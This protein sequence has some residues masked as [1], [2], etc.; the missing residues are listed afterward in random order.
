[1]RVTRHFAALRGAFLLALLA[2]PPPLGWAADP[3]SVLLTR[4][5]ATNDAPLYLSGLSSGTFV[6]LDGR[7]T[8]PIDQVNDDYCDCLDGSDEPGTAAC[9]GAFNVGFWCPSVGF[10][11]QRVPSTRVADG[12]CDCCDGSDELM[13]HHVHCDNTCAEQAAKVAQEELLRRERIE[14]A[15]SIRS[16]AIAKGREAK[17][18]RRA[19]AAELPERVEAAT[20]LVEHWET[21]LQQAEAL[22]REEKEALETVAVSTFQKAL[23]LLSMPHAALADVLLDI[24]L[25]KQEE[26]GEALADTVKGVL[27]A[28]H[29]FEDTAVLSAALPVTQDDTPARKILRE[30]EERLAEAEKAAEAA[31][32]DSSSAGLAAQNVAL[33]KEEVEAAKGPLEAERVQLERER[34]V[35]LAQAIRL[36]A[37]STEQIAEVLFIVAKTT[38]QFKE[39]TDFVKIRGGAD[40]SSVVPGDS[41][42]HRRP[43]ADHAREQLAAAKTERDKLQD[44]RTTLEEED[45]FDYGPNDEYYVLKGQCFDRKAGAHTYTFCPF[46]TSRQDTRSLGNFAGWHKKSDWHSQYRQMRFTGGDRFGCSEDRELTV[47]IDCG[48][49][50]EVVKVEEPSMCKYAMVFVCP[51]ACYDDA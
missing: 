37:L 35:L 17:E 21:A 36:D 39:L 9:G 8:I 43:E 13:G 2:G 40:A 15:H 32:E 38:K 48:E 5:V 19:R 45:S 1:M 7:R 31:K 34:R 27:G 24:S 25:N 6:C 16:E 11:P 3:L 41:V 44:D 10:R 28:A 14:R 22:E 33:R 12:I 49:S 18:S 4:G 23:A 29:D 42:A 47:D 50:S 26:S 46:G 20:N 30:A 51:Q